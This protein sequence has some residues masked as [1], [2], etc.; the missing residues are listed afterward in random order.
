MTTDPTAPELFVRKI[1]DNAKWQPDN[2]LVRFADGPN[3]ETDGYRSLTW[4]QYADGV[5]RTAYWLDETFGKA[6]SNDTVAYSGPS[7][8]RYAILFAASVKTGRKFLVPDGRYMKDGLGALLESSNCNIWLYS[9]GGAFSPEPELEA[10]RVRVQK[11]HPLSWCLSAKGSPHYPYDKTYEEA[12]NDEIL[13]I[14]T[15]GTTGAPKPIF[16]NNGFWAAGCSSAAL[17]RRHWPRGI[18][19]DSFYGR[20][21]ILAIPM[22]LQPGLVLI[23]MFAVFYN[24][25]VIQPPPDVVGLPPDVFKKM[26]RLNKV[27]GLMGFPFTIVDLYKNEET[28]ESLKSLEFITY[29]GAA[30]DREVGDALCEHTRLNSV[31]GATESGGRFSLHPVDR[32][33]WYT[34]QFI[35]EHHVRLVKLEGSGA[36]LGDE[37]DVYQMFID[38]PPD[39]KPSIHQC[40]FWNYKMFDGVESIDTKELWRPVQDADGSTRWESVAR[41]DDWLKLI[42][43][44]KFHAQDIETKVARFPG[45]KNVMVGGNQRVAPY[46]L[47]EVRHEL[48][49]R[50]P[51]QLLD[52]IYA[53]TIV[54]INDGSAKAVAIPRETVFLAKKEKP[55]KMTLKQLVLR[56]EVERDYQE[57][58]EEAYERL[59]NASKPTSAKFVE[60]MN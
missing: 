38:R 51:E 55:I 52:D 5:N 30:L 8:V 53:K 20:S 24:T 32:K 49:D 7:D 17:S 1:D 39:G 40:A 50:D 4:R 57:E 60:N 58:I 3:W 13:I 12:K 6:E 9:E 10:T 16:M 15:G 44:A 45:V 41:T 14:H 47:V 23:D 19:T 18:S 31:M 2:V 21:L 26:L 59:K 25:C 36:A 35:P 56:R 46:V 43:M 34:F 37:S 48:L 54:G 29:L 42:W 33:L 27:D 22:R 11:Y 28:R